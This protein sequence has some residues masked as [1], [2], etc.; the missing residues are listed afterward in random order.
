MECLGV[1][2]TPVP[3]AKWE[4]AIMAVLAV[5]VTS[6]LVLLLSGSA[7]LFTLHLSVIAAVLVFVLTVSRFWKILKSGRLPLQ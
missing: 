3:F 2:R 6:E 1:Q 7:L 4:V 5:I